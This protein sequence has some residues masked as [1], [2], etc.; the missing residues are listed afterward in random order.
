M[1]TTVLVTGATGWLGRHTLDALAGHSGLRVIAAARDASRVPPAHTAQARIGDLTDP[2]YRHTVVQGVDVLIHA[3]TWSSFWG[4]ASHERSL[5]LEPSIDLIDRAVE[6]G[7]G[8]IVLASTIAIGTPARA[9]AT[10]AAADAPV[11]RG[12]WPH[13]DAMVAVEQHARGAAGTGP[14][15]TTVVSARLGHF[16]GPG[17]SLGLVSALVPRLRTRMVP[18]VDRGSARMPLI[19]GTDLGRAMALA[20]LAP[21]IEGYVPIPIVGAEQPTS[22]EAISHIAE[23]ANVPRPVY[24][25]PTRAAFG[26]AALM[27]RLHPVLPGTSP[28][29]TRALVHVGLDWHSD[30][31][32]ARELLGFEARVDWRDAVAASVADR[33]ALGFPWPELTQRP[34]QPLDWVSAPQLPSGR[35]SPSVHTRRST[36]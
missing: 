23:L 16:V 31:A 2:T 11:A 26:F 19:D 25:V 12:Y 30:P 21:G 13:L 35:P 4:H 36:S 28:F 15:S 20:A 3:G 18:W 33:R 8:R 17:L 27:E 29:L 14:G 22:R 32:T 10:V 6:A 1:P 24:S 7:V 34:T 5:F 9:G